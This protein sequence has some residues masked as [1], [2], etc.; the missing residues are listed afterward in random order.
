M[1][2]VNPLDE[3]ELSELPLTENKRFHIVNLDGANW[4]LRKLHAIRAKQE[5]INALADDEV[6]RIES[7][8]KSELKRHAEDEAY[9][10]MLLEEY[11]TEVLKA[12]PKAKTISTPYGKLKS[13]QR[14]PSPKKVNE[15][16]LLMHLKSSGFAE[17]I[18]VKE[19]ADWAA[20]KATL[21]IV[22]TGNRYT[23]VDEAGQEVAGVEADMGGISYSVEVAK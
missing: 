16:Q 9:F 21:Q 4:A 10:L 22:D 14:K 2:V 15:E 23:V 19:I 6:Q 1:S 8:R 18:K 12:D 3:M 7:W 13:V 5:E 17:F 11:H 20:F